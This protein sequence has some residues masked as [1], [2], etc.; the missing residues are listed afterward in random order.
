M[1]W[2]SSSSSSCSSTRVITQTAPCYKRSHT[3][4]HSRCQANQWMN[5]FVD[6]HMMGQIK[7][8]AS[9]WERKHISSD[10]WLLVR[11]LYL[12]MD[13]VTCSHVAVAAFQIISKKVGS[14]YMDKTRDNGFIY[15]TNTVEDVSL[16]WRRPASTFYSIFLLIYT[17]S[18]STMN[19]LPKALPHNK[20]SGCSEYLVSASIKWSSCS[21]KA[22]QYIMTNPPCHLP[23]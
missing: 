2:S 20:M 17:T 8:P 22:D 18:M 7:T 23:T 4:M 5:G 15:F 19:W 3:L 16:E 14:C 11:V 9:T 12:W 6:L 10:R 13:V 21:F 1:L